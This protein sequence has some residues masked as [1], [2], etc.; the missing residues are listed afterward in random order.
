M[1]IVRQL[2]DGIPAPSVSVDLGCGTGMY[3]QML[4]ALCPVI[5]LDPSAEMLRIAQAKVSSRA[6][7]VQGGAHPIPLPDGYVDFVVAARSLCHESHLDKALREIAR[8]MRSGGLLVVS[9]VHAHHDFS[10]TRITVGEADVYIETIKR[11]P[12]DILSA[13][14]EAGDWTPGYQREFGWRDLVWRPDDTRFNRIDRSGQRPIFF[15]LAL[16]RR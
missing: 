11:T 8:V 12:K 4:E 5:G 2:F 1:P 13:A 14:A 9:D 6:R 3:T 7:L 10:H 16:V 15:A